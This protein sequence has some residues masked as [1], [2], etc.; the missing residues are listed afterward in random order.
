MAAA[1]AT[2]RLYGPQGNL[3]SK[4]AEQFPDQTNGGI[5][6]NVYPNIAAPVWNDY[7]ASLE[8]YKAPDLDWNSLAGLGHVDGVHRLHRH[9][10][11]T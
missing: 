4:V 6:M 10:A 5:V 1:G 2:P 11:R 3:D 7:R 8:K 9:R